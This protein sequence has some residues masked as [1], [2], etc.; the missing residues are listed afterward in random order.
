MCGQSLAAEVRR[1]YRG[2]WKQAAEMR[3][4]PAHGGRNGTPKRL[5]ARSK[6]PKSRFPMTHRGWEGA[7]ARLSGWAQGV[8]E[9]AG[10]LE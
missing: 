1:P 3:R 10:G 2:R 5:Q 8:S 9:K 6:D 4:R 7:W